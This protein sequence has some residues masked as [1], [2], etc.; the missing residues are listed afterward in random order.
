M[1]QILK[2]ILF[3]SITAFIAFSLIKFPDQALEASI[4]GLNIWWEVVFPSLLPFFITAELL[5]SFGVVKFIGVLFEPIMRPLFNLPGVGSFG[6]MMGMASGYPTGAK[7]ASRLREEQQL[8]QIEA[9]RLVSFTNASSPLFIFAAISVG[10]FHDTKLGI[11]LAACHYISNA[12]VGICMRFY[13]RKQD[14]LSKKHKGKVSLTAAFHEM[15]QTRLGD[16]RPLGEILG[17]SVINSVKTLVTVGGF[18]VLFSVLTKLFFLVGL[19]S[20]IGIFF[21][22]LLQLFSMSPDFALP[23]LSG[24]FEIT[25]GAQ[26][27]SHVNDTLLI[28]AILVSFILGFNGFSV[29]AQVASVLAKT[30][31]R[32]APYFFARILHGVIAS[33]LTIILYKPLYLDK[34][35]FD[36]NDIPVS[37]STSDS[38]W[39][40]ILNQLAEIGPMVTIL[41]LCAAL[42]I[43]YRKRTDIR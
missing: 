38:L 23:L 2:T 7:I 34:Q 39:V 27:I 29:Q 41:S 42:I 3:S 1:T 17:D 13:G 24:L 14:K 36:T 40:T 37:I 32:F 10:F 4:R 21:E 35:A 16:K 43:A 26:S 8:S 11:L 18:I 25:I 30:D 20:I 5:I 19:S 15:H 33:I 9:E 28:Q 31:I 12:I 6:W 22:Q